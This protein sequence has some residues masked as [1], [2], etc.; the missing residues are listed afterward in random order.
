MT[1]K[2][3]IEKFKQGFILDADGLVVVLLLQVG[4]KYTVILV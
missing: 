1:G 3:K 2:K 4:L